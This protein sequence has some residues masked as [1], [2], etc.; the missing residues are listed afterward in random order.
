M[1]AT[2]ARLLCIIVPCFDEE[3]V[4]EATHAELKRVLD[5]L[6]RW[7][8]LIYFVDDGSRDA[9]LLR[10]RALE[11]RDECTR[12][13]SLSRNFGH[14]IAITA[15]LDHAD[16]RADAV[17]VM[18]ADL[19]NPPSL[20]PRLIE[21]LERGHDVVMGVRETGRVVG[22]WR[23]SLSRAFYALFNRVSQVSI[24][25]GAPDFFLLSRRARE[26]LGRMGDQ[27]RF[28]RAMVAWIGL[29]RTHVPYVPPA[30]LA[31]Q[32]KYTLGRMLRL[33]ADAIFA[34]SSAPLLAVGVLGSAT[35]LV[36]AALL[37][38]SALSTQLSFLPGLLCLLA[39]LQLSA[40]AL[41][42]AYVGRIFEH[43]QGRP[44]YI[45]REASED[46]ASE[47]RILD[48]GQRSARRAR[49]Q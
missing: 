27:R 35:F 39:G 10:L 28:L 13:L 29:P 30:R 46:S 4:V 45:V 49:G 12:V 21:Q 44:L 1:D 36:G 14:Q 18:D 2:G 37:T 22:W 32:S 48:V 19:E 16:R 8:H 7:R 25:S 33:A 24:A 11:R 6:P 38:W 47:P 43:S 17:L 20:I 5:A 41:V 15:G 34:F 26:A 40:I 23:R 42:G 9:T 31:G 3:Q